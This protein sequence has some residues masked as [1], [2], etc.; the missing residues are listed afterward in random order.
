VI[1]L[2]TSFLFPLFARHDPDHQRVREVVESLRDKTLSELVLTTNH[3]VA[4]T[5]TLVRYKGSRRDPGV[6][7]RLAVEV[8]QALYSG[9]LATIHNASADEERAAFDYFARHADQKYSMV[10]CLSFVVMEKLGIKEA[11]AVDE[12]FTHRFVARPGPS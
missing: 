9:R 10:D 6:A 3:V 8:G 1:F 5:V 2:D 12:D 11:L 7:H 4:E